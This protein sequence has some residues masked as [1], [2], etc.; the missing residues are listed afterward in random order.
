MNEKP[1]N[2]ALLR[3][4]EA[5]LAQAARIQEDL[6]PKASPK[7]EGFDMSGSNVPCYEVGG[8]YYDF[9]PIDDDRVGVVIAD[10]S[11]KG[12]SAAL[13]MAS[14]RAALLGEVRPDYDLGTMAARLSDFVYRSSGPTS[15]VTFFFAEVDRRTEELRYI[16]AGHNPPFVLDKGGRA[17]TIEG[18]GFPL[19]MFSGS[20]Y[21]TRTAPLARGE[22]AVLF[23][24][25]IPEAR[26]AEGQEYSEDRLRTLVRDN[27]SASASDICRQVLSDVHGFAGDDQPCDDITLVV[28]KRTAVGE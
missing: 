19:G 11:G 28:L 7:L 13:L 9:V 5:D 14:L 23:T 2:E 12:I 17:R 20:R 26:N 6:L 18:S 1:K 8:D 25:G 15:F 3:R 22:I 21:E 4:I 10:V 24:D 27:R 16:N